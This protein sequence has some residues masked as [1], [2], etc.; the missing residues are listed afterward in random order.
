MR[1]G[2]NGAFQ[3]D[4]VSAMRETP[5]IPVA[6]AA[7]AGQR[8]A[9]APPEITVTIGAVELQAAPLAPAPAPAVPARREPRLSLDEYLQR[10][11]KGRS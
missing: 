11:A 9:P 6:P 10:R 5:I 3:A 2:S 4:A 8:G 7:A 1:R